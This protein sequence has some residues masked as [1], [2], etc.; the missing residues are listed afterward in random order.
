[1][2]SVIAFW[3]EIYIIEKQFSVLITFYKGEICFNI[4]MVIAVAFTS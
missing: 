3:V 1:M 2:F 4:E